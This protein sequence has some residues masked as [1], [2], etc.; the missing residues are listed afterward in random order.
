MRRLLSLI[1]AGDV[2]AAVL[3][4]LLVGC[5]TG[6]PGG[7]GPP[8]APSGS[9]GDTKIAVVAAENFWGSI[10]A[11]L[12]GEQ[13]SVRSI[14]A[15]P[16]ADP[17]DY[18][19][20]AADGRDVARA[21]YVIANGAGYD[22]WVTKLVDANPAPARSVLMV[23]E[24]LGVNEGGN[25]HR[26]YSP[27]DVHRVIEQITADYKRIDPADAAYFDQQK[28]AYKTQGLARY[29]Q[30]IA[31]IRN[32]YGGTPIGASESIVTVLTEDLGLKML[33]PESFLDAV[34]EGADP[35]ATDKIAVDQQIK[36]KQIKIFVFNSQNSTPDVAAL[37]AEAQAQGIPVATVTETPV[38][39]TA[40]FQDWQA[41]Q[42]EG[43]WNALSK[44][45]IP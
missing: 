8:G 35:T 4:G 11:Q 1:R 27:D 41:D 2:T 40:R 42:L 21:Q 19:P 6:L 32:K 23:G 15:S 20:T 36:A 7:N 18:E 16:D 39:A 29:N 22:P 17:H 24:L 14:I 31:E 9:T 44:A 34:S 33:T 25:P 12:G 13:V 45:T 30:L 26:W 37:V 3:A 38:P 28:H 10:A 43:I 5:S